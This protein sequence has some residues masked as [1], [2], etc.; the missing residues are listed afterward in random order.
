MRKTT[1]A[2]FLTG[3]LLASPSRAQSNY[4][5][6]SAMEE[7]VQI[8][9]RGWMFNR[10]DRGSMS[11]VQ[12]VASS[13]DGRTVVIYGEYTYNGGRGGWVR[14]RF[15]GGQFSCI[16]FHDFAGTCRA[17]GR[18]PSQG[19]V[20]GVLVVAVAGAVLGSQSSGGSGGYDSAGEDCRYREPIVNGHDQDG[21]PIIVGWECRQ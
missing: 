20:A 1:I 7:L 12:Q 11:N 21:R 13:P 16:E 5:P 18:S 6:A 3:L 14:A 15:V 2:A 17:L 10:Y 8:D 9:A 19:I 4:D